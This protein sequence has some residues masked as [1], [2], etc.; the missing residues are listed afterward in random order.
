MKS[1]TKDQAEHKFLRIKG[2]LT[3]IAG[4]LP[5]IQSW[6]LKLV[7]FPSPPSCTSLQR[8]PQY[9]EVPPNIEAKRIIS[10]PSAVLSY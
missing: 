3:E 1:G 10:Y 5:I 6:K 7:S 9:I 4:E 2:T 8:I